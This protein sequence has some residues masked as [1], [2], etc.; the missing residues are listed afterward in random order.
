MHL[1]RYTPSSRRL[2]ACPFL[3]SIHSLPLPSLPIISFP[4]HFCTFCTFCTSMYGKVPAHLP[5]PQDIP[6]RYFY[7]AA[8]RTLP[9]DSPWSGQ[10]W[11]SSRL[12][13]LL[14][15]A[16]AVLVPPVVLLLLKLH[17]SASGTYRQPTPQTIVTRRLL[18]FV[19]AASTATTSSTSLHL[20]IHAPAPAPGLHTAR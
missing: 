7:V 6:L 4:P 1:G 18:L 12:D 19:F 17:S 8:P 15:F 10:S 20:G 16:P 5:L 14:L 3:V 13:F 2:H 11:L 9:T